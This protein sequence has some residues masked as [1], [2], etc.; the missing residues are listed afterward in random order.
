MP[1]EGKHRKL[2]GLSLACHDGK[3]GNNT[4]VVS[5]GSAKAPY[6]LQGYLASLRNTNIS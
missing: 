6:L 4:E 2:K 1:N 3:E 5:H